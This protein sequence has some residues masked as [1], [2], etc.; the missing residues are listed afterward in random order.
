MFIE[1]K[2]NTIHYCYFSIEKTDQYVKEW[3]GVD[4]FGEE[5]SSKPIYHLG[6]KSLDPNIFNIVHNLHVKHTVK[7]LLEFLDVKYIYFTKL[8]TLSDNYDINSKELYG[9]LR[10]KMS[11][12]NPEY[13]RSY[14]I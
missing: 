12:H 13:D 11:T 5:F 8:I 9:T 3:I 14:P 7:K 2:N 1:T 4:L 6:N 10:I